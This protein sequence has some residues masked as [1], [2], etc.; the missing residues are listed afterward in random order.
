MACA[1]GSARAD[2]GEIMAESCWTRIAQHAYDEQDVEIC[3]RI[4]TTGIDRETACNPFT[5]R[6]LDAKADVLFDRRSPE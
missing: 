1:F 6:M 4:T 2:D 5:G 3:R